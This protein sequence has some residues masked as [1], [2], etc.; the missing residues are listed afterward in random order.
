[1]VVAGIVLYSY[2]PI[3]THSIYPP[4]PFH[5]L[6]G[7]YCPG[8]GSLRA[9]HQLLHGNIIS[10]IHFNILMILLLPLLI[11]EMFILPLFLLAGKAIPHILG[12]GV[13]PLYLLVLIIG[14]WILR[15][16]PF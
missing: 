3:D 14:Y 16:I 11:Y 9:I 13:K 6:T 5:Y 1:M 4:C 7:F 8:C 10:A 12:K 15:N 2:N